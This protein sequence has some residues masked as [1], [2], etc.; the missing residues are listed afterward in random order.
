MEPGTYR[1]WTERNVLIKM[2]NGR[3]FTATF[4]ELTPNQFDLVDSENGAVTVFRENAV[5]LVGQKEFW[6]L[7]HPNAPRRETANSSRCNRGC[8]GAATA[9]DNVPPWCLL[10][11]HGRLFGAR[12]S[13]D[14]GQRGNNCDS[15]AWAL[16]QVTWS[17]TPPGSGSAPASGFGRSCWWRGPR[18]TVF[19]RRLGINS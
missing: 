1:L 2:K 15:I 3:D 7:P 4:R 9:F 18:A 6:R 8:T 19:P 13:W 17:A 12:Q 16:P 14:Q 10:E 5:A 11:M